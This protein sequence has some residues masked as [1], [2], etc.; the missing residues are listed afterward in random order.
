[1]AARIESSEKARIAA[2]KE[3]LGPSG[4]AQ[5]KKELDEAQAEH[6]TPIPKEILTGFPV[7]DVKS[8]SWIP[9]QSVQEVG[10]GRKDGGK[11]IKTGTDVAR[12]VEK[13]GEE[14]PFFVQYDHVKVGDHLSFTF[15]EVLEDQLLSPICLLSFLTSRTSSACML[16]SPYKTFPTTS[17]CKHPPSPHN[18]LSH[19]PMPYSH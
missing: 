5:A 15:P 19:F 9:V 14:L 8:I 13:D 6:D 7:P 10:K 3:S 18:S 12:H 16:S 11:G 1:M 4:L 17:D 2:Q